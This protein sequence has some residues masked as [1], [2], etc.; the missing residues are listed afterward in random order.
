MSRAGE[1]AGA[2]RQGQEQLQ[3]LATGQGHRGA[4][5]EVEPGADGKIFDHAGDGN[6]S[7]GRL[8]RRPGRDVR[9]WAADTAGGE[10]EFSRMH[11][12]PQGRLLLDQ[13][14]CAF[15]RADRVAPTSQPWPGRPLDA[16]RPRSTATR[17][18]SLV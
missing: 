16:L 8:A 9:G 6:L 13:G 5:G 12:Q 14:E 15:D 11:R 17:R 4:W 18:S 2:R 3:L 7:G 1:S 10:L